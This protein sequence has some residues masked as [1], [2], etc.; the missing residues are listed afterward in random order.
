MRIALVLGLVTMAGCNQILGTSQA[1]HGTCDPDAPFTHI[2]PVG[3]L[4]SDLGEQSVALSRDELTV[5]CS[6]LTT[7]G[8]ENAPMPRFGDL[9]MAQRD[10]LSEDFHN[11]VPL[12]ALNTDA[13]ELGASLSDDQHMLYFARG[14]PPVRYKIF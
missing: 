6:R 10:H 1:R 12:D 7:T 11:I 4:E 3:G 14:G 9:Y 2:A 8:P 13:N 5:V